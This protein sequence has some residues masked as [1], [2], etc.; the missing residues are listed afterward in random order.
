ME[1]RNELVTE[2][3]YM[4][5]QAAGVFV[6]AEHLGCR[7]ETPEGTTLYRQGDAGSTF[8]FVVSGRVQVEIFQYDGAEFILELMGSGALIGEGSAMAGQR[9]MS[10]ATT[11]EP[12]V[13][14]EFDYPDVKKAF[15]QNIEFATALMEVVAVKQW[16]LGMRIQF[17]A[18][19]R[20]DL[21][22]VE[23]LSRLAELYGVEDSDGIR[24]RTPLTH[25]QVAA[26]TGTSRVTVTRTITRLKSEGVL[27]NEGRHFWMCH[28]GRRAREHRH[29]A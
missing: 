13:L 16:V 29:A 7:R 4:D 27:L 25:G 8:Y 21:R 24:I 6:A 5:A 1:T 14:I 17:L 28:Q 18:T 15:P 2:T 12:C 10:T 22:I 11:L 23:L 26:L 19:P 9:R 3:W 20:P